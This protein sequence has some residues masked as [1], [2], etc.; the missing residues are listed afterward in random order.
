MVSNIGDGFKDQFPQKWPNFNPL[1]ADPS[2]V[3]RIE[4]EALRREIEE[5]KNLLVAAKKFDEAT[6]QPH[7]EMDE[8]VKLIKAIAKM[9][10]VDLGDV[11]G[12]EKPSKA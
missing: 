5:L 12:T 10:G 2:S 3:S 11:F 1:P 6:G 9:V 8:K 4:F 7:C